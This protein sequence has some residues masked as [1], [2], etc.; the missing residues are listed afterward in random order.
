MLSHRHFYRP[1]THF[2]SLRWLDRVWFCPLIFWHILQLR[3]QSCFTFSVALEVHQSAPP[4]ASRSHSGK[5]RGDQSGGVCLL[6]LHCCLPQE[7]SESLSPRHFSGRK[8]SFL[9]LQICYPSGMDSRVPSTS[10]LL[11]SSFL[12]I[13]ANNPNVFGFDFFSWPLFP[14]GGHIYSFTCPRGFLLPSPVY[15][16]SCHISLRSLLCQSRSQQETDGTLTLG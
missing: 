2:V 14:V 15:W 5:G 1:R 6:S 10:S 16:C 9:T 4:F 3:K 12:G 13:K 11:C 8:K 7:N